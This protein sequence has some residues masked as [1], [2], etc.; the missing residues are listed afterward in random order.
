[1]NRIG[2]YFAFWEREWEADYCRYIEKAKRL[3]FD[4]LEL[5]AGCLPGLGRE[6]RLEI[7]GRAADAGL[8]LTYCIG[9]PEIY[10]PA[11]P[12]TDTR[13]KGIRFVQELLRC[14]HEMGG[15]TIGGILYSCWPGPVVSWEEKKQAEERSLESMREIGKAALEYDVNC[16]LEVVNR[17]EQYLLNT[18]QEGTAF[19]RRLENPRMKLLLDSFHMNIEEDS[20]YGAI[21]EA[22]EVLGHFHIGECNRKTPGQGRMDWDSI[23]RGLRDINYQGR[24]VMEPFIRPGGQ[25]GRDIKIYRDQSGWAGEEQMDQMAREALC[26]IRRKLKETEEGGH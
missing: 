25:V 12:D 22:K 20:L 4:T 14:V 3:G 15:D 19:V 5:A 9:L 1:M 7:A 13:K 8:D 26:F 16:C 21:V 2:I 10:D 23:V 17:F 11:S 6:K 18:A 24:I